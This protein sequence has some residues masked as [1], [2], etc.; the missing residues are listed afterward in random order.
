MLYVVPYARS[1]FGETSCASRIRDAQSPP[2]YSFTESEP[3]TKGF[4]QNL[5]HSFT[6]FQHGLT[7]R[8]RYA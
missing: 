5:T 7:K 4:V 6:A 8:C 3:A 2:I 1:I